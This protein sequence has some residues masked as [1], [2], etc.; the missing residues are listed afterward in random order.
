ML[1]CIVQVKAWSTESQPHEEA[2]QAL[3]SMLPGRECTS[4]QGA[5]VRFG[6]VA[7]VADSSQ[8]VHV[9]H[10]SLASSKAA[11]ATKR[12]GCRGHAG[13]APEAV[14]SQAHA[15][16]RWTC[17]PPRLLVCRSGS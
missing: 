8:H 16:A 6:F 13:E 10:N 17:S 1:H 3:P 11:Q 15:A 12:T 5:S 14:M 2:K 4:Q 9:H 7:F